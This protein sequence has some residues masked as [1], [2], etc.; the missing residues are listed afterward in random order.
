MS[1]YELVTKIRARQRLLHHHVQLL[2]GGE[3]S[4]GAG[5]KRF[6]LCNFHYQA[7]S[8]VSCSISSPSHGSS[9]AAVTATSS[10]TSAVTASVVVEA[11]DR[12]I[13]KLRPPSDL[14]SALFFIGMRRREMHAKAR[15]NIA[16]SDSNNDLLS[17]ENDIATT[18]TKTPT[19]T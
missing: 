4:V 11:D 14:P 9:I 6:P 12:M 2:S 10:L 15:A 8:S 16:L 5:V 7:M 18:R 17:P 1:C 19:R 3:Q 13:I